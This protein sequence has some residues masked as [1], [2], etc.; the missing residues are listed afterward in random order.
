MQ[1]ERDRTQARL[2][3]LAGVQ[4]PVD[5]LAEDVAFLT[6]KGY[7]AQQARDMAEFM[8]RKIQPLAQRNHQLEAQMQGS[9]MAQ[10]AYTDAVNANPAL[11]ADPKIAE[12]TWR[13]LNQAA[14]QGDPRYVT[15]QYAEA[16]AAQEYALQHKP[17]ANP[18]TP[19][20]PVP[21]PGYLPRPMAPL[22]FNGPGSQYSPQPPQAPP[23]DPNVDRVAD[24]MAKRWSNGKTL[25]QLEQ[26]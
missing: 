5:P 9:A 3:A 11:F 16:V 19:P 2:Q 4:P 21:M 22:G 24:E 15:A 1:A 13:A 17:W 20:P 10:Q 12:T 25:S 6:S 14:M 8:N 26:K 23:S 7:E 18:N